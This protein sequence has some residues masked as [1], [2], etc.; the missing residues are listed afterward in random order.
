M[1][2]RSGGGMRELD[3]TTPSEPLDIHARGHFERFQD[4][5][6]TAYPRTRARMGADDFRELVGDYLAAQPP[7]QRSAH[8]AGGALPGFVSHH[9]LAAA[10]PALCDLARLEWARDS[11]LHDADARTLDRETFLEASAA[12]PEGFSFG[13]IPAIRVL[14][15]EANALALWEALPRDE[16]HAGSDSDK[17]PCV[18]VWRKG[19]VAFHRRG[20]EDEERCLAALAAGGITLPQLVELL[21]KPDAGAERTS[22][23]FAALLE[24]WLRD[25]LLTPATR[26][27]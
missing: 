15:L 1:T 24:L 12:D 18:L 6:A 5:I 19:G 17:T 25:E 8:E 21:L 22:E 14:T 4:C 16:N 20:E 13:L 9:R 11:V 26:E 10:V 23:R 27:A 7:A 2:E 3:R